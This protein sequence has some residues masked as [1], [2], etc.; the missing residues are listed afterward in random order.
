MIKKIIHTTDSY[1]LLIL[2]IVLGTVLLTH[3]LQ[4]AFGWFHGLGW[5]NSINY[6]TGTV[7]LP[8][9][10]AALVILIETLG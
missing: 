6:F 2:R 10:L 5:N 3:G 4:K 8:Y 7:G 9:A 1:N